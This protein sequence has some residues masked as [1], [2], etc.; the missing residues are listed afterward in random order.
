[1]C[2]RQIGVTAR[3]TNF[4]TLKKIVL[5]CERKN[6]DGSRTVVLAPPRKEG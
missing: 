4:V 5:I 3:A 1:M 2:K 6:A